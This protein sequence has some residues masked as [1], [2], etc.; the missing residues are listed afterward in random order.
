MVEENSN[1]L[2]TLYLSLLVENISNNDDHRGSMAYVYL[3]L[4]QRKTLQH[5]LGLTE[6][7]VN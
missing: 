2:C 6:L 1:S 4:C 5:T 7:P 3:N